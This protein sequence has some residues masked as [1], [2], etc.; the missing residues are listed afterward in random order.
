MATKIGY[1]RVSSAA[2]DLTLQRDA[3]K[4][5]GCKIIREEKVTGTK[6]KGRPEL[7][8]ILDFI[9]IGDQLVVTKLDRLARDLRDLQNICDEIAVKDASLAVLDQHVDTSTAVGKAFFQML[10]VFAEFE[11]NIRRERQM[12]G[13]EKAKAAGKYEGRKRTVKPK[14]AK[15]LESKGLNVSQ[16]AEELG[17]SRASVYPALGRL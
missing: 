6:R 15:Q 4:T 10:G 9:R 2:Q 16:I 3:L 12:A 14:K 5:A 11:N 13:I 7:K 17:T 1:A 8:S